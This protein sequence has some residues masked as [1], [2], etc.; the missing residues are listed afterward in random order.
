MPFLALSG[1]PWNFLSFETSKGV[2]SYVNEVT[3]GLLL[4]EETG[5]LGDRPRV[6]EVEL[7]VLSRDVWIQSIAD[8]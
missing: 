7:S 1:N 8:G 5:C 2:F 6:R 3:F 4:K